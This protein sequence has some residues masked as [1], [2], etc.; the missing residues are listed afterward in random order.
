MKCGKQN[1]RTEIISM[2]NT[3][4][5][6]TFRIPISSYLS[7]PGLWLRV[8]TL[9]LNVMI[10]FGWCIR[11]GTVRFA[12]R[13]IFPWFGGFSVRSVTGQMIVNYFNIFISTLKTEKSAHTLL[14]PPGTWRSAVWCTAV[15][16]CVWRLACPLVSYTASAWSVLPIG[17]RTYSAFGATEHY[18]LI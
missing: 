5:Q 17:G 3:E 1:R 14:W 9:L 6:Q 18:K 12:V 8:K 2:P 4:E 15:G 7:S 11:S 16:E 10:W 13:C